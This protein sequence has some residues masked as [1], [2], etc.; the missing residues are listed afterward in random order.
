[1]SFGVYDITK[2]FFRHTAEFRPV[3]AL[4]LVCS[5]LLLQNCSEHTGGQLFNETLP[6]KAEITRKQDGNNHL[7]DQNNSALQPTT[8]SVGTMKAS[9]AVALSYSADIRAAEALRDQSEVN[10]SIARSGYMPSLQSSLESGTG[11]NYD[12]RLA[13]TQPIYDF[14]RTG[15]KVAGAQAGKNIAHERLRGT[16]EQVALEMAQ[17]YIA[18]KRFEALASAARENIAVHKNFVKLASERAQGGVADSTE[19]QLAEIQLSE[20]S[21][22]LEDVEGNLRAARSNF[23]SLTGYQ[24]GKLSDVV[25]LDLSAYTPNALDI[26]NR[27]AQAPAV[28]LARAQEEQALRTVDEEKASLLPTLSAEVYYRDG[29]NRSDSR[30]GA[31]LKIVGPTLNGLSN[32]QRVSA[33][34][35]AANSY[36]WSSEAARRKITLQLNLYRDQV[37]TL[38]EQARLLNTQSVKSVKLRKLYESQFM[39]GTR[40]FNDLINIQNDISNLDNRIV[41]ASYDAIQIE[42]N[43]ASQLGELLN[44]LNIEDHGL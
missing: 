5:L 21:S 7:T 3:K 28:K 12:Y 6:G 30:T 20:A 26:P 39:I 11:S 38:T 43:V 27:L 9:I 18:I 22:T 29:E 4:F 8:K 13:L 33:L 42:Y 37:P 15:A 23:Y 31:G 17:A 24:A 44:L 10:V 36:R 2:Y 40:D 25:R 1:M 41:N 19:E 14:G 32:F 35:K 16:Q 34:N